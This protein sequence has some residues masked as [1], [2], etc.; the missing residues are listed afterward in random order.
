MP[1]IAIL[2]PTAN[3]RGKL[4]RQFNYILRCLSN[5]TILSHTSHQFHFFIADGTYEKLESDPLGHQISLFI[6]S[7]SAFCSIEYIHVPDMHFYER[8]NILAESS[9]T[10]LAIIC[11]DD[12]LLVFDHIP[13]MAESLCSDSSARTLVGRY[14]NIRRFDESCLHYDVN[15]R[16][17]YCFAI[18]GG[19]T[20]T[21]YAQ[22]V[23]LNALGISSTFY[24]IQYLEDLKALTR[25]L[26]KNKNTIY[27][28]GAEGIHQAWCCRMGSILFSE[29][30]FLL[31]DF[32][33][34]D[35]VHEP[36]R[37]APSTDEF[38]G[39]GH[40]AALLINSI[41]SGSGNCLPPATQ[42]DN[43]TFIRDLF[44]LSSTIQSSRESLMAAVNSHMLASFAVDRLSDS[45]LSCAHKAWIGTI[46][47]AYPRIGL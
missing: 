2:I 25:I 15:E 47:Y 14:L 45:T 46:R 12:D 44:Q 16:P 5:G 21:R 22:Y 10:E 41:I 42:N 11:G 32:T 7:I 18:Q 23:S 28:G 27:F 37:E 33:Y 19:S 6:D 43:Y 24:S 35:Y 17:Y 1:N 30:P 20:Q 8:L 38:P 9:K 26:T 34:I 13:K 39:V 31:R 29:L 36:Q 3:R 4:I 40:E